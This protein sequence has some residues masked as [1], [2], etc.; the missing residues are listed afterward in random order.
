MDHFKDAQSFADQ[1][2]WMIQGSVEG[3]T[4]ICWSRRM[5]DWWITFKVARSFPYQ[6]EWMIDEHLQGCKVICCSRR[7]DDWWRISL[8]TH[9]HLLIK[10]NDDCQITFTVARSFADQEEWMIDEHLQACKVICCSRRMG[11]WWWISLRTHSLLLS[12]RMEN[13]HHFNGCMVICWSRRMDDWRIT[14]KVARSFT[15]Q[16]EWMIDETPSRLQ[17][18]L[19]ILNNGWLMMDQFKDAQSF[20][21]HEEWR[22]DKSRLRMHGHLLIKTNGWLMNY[23]LGC[24]FISWSRRMHDWRNTFKIAESFADPEEWMPGVSCL[25]LH[26]HLLSKRMDDWRTPSRL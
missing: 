1:E 23:V 12:R 24:T 8:R 7:M 5:D 19:L 14:F 16:E 18:H 2:E 15:D 20:V 25:R 22:I 17:N 21:D 6:E 3:R 26:G 10:K 4:G 9:S 13:W 11:D